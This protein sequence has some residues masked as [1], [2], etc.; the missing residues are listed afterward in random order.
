MVK[1]VLIA[2]IGTEP[3]VVT[4]ALDLLL[5]KGYSIGEVI[6]VHTVGDAVQPALAALAA[7]FARLGSCDYRLVPVEDE[8][9]PVAD[10]VTEADL[11]A[12]LRTLYRTVLA[13][14]RAGRLVHL[15]IAGGRKPMAVYGMVVAQLLFDEDDR[16]W[17][18][19][20]EGWQP[21][22]ERVM[23]VRP[24]DRVWLVPVPVLRWS[25]VSPVLTELALREDPWEAIQAQRT[26]RREEEWRRK[27]EFVERRLTSAERE[28]ARLVCLG[29]DNAAI[30]RKLCKS[31][32]TVANQLTSIYNKLHE[33]RGYRADIPVSRSF[34]IAEFAAYF[35][36]EE[37]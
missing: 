37:G 21:G 28:V 12:F 14:K 11:A 36:M 26:M 18:L 22:A 16:V 7:E 17:H 13:E 1:Q 24:G 2:T 25:S 33:W 29:L 35:A 9:G 20:S 27:R 6:V 15:S 31:E 30:A 23:H 32:S 19:L 4:L 5:A 8:R 34:L 3:Q 10:L